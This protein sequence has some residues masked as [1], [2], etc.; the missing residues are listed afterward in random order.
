MLKTYSTYRSDPAVLQAVEF[1]KTLGERGSKYSDLISPAPP[2]SAHEELQW[3][4]LVV[5]GELHACVKQHL[6]LISVPLDVKSKYARLLS[7]IIC[8]F[9]E[10]DRHGMAWQTLQLG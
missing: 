5:A 10:T 6:I 9:P 1:V 3:V 8:T 2:G 4:D 7:H